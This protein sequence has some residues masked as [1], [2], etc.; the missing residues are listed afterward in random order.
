[1]R[2]IYKIHI[3]DMIDIWD[4]YTMW[5]WIGAYSKIVKVNS[6][7]LNPGKFQFIILGTNTDLFLD[8]NKIEKSQEVAV[9]GITI[10]DKLSF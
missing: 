6:L 2:Y 4:T 3:W 10:N 7:E 5:I 9:L 8:G 1:M